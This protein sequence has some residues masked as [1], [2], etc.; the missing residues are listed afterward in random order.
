VTS[1]SVC[2]SV[3]VS[4]SASIS[5]KP[6]ARSSSLLSTFPTAVA[7]FSSGGVAMR[8]VLPVLWMTSYLF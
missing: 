5:P 2:L 8:Y 3:C 1:V 4:M 7:C 6:H